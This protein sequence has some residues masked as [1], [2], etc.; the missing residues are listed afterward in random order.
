MIFNAASLFISSIRYL[1]LSDFVRPLI[2]VYHTYFLFKR[3][4]CSLNISSAIALL[5]LFP[6]SFRSALSLS[7]AASSSS[8]AKNAVVAM[9]NL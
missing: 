1:P 8:P 4:L 3:S 2:F 5:T 9:P 7:A 6:W